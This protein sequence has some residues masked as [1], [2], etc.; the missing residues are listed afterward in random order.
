MC[1]ILRHIT[2]STDESRKSVSSPAGIRI[3]WLLTFEKRRW[4]RK[5]SQS[6]RLDFSHDHK[7]LNVLALNL[8]LFL[9]LTPS[10]AACGPAKGWMNGETLLRLARE[11]FTSCNRKSRSKVMNQE[12]DTRSEQKLLFRVILL[13]D[14]D[15]LGWQV[16][17]EI[18]NHTKKKREKRREKSFSHFRLSSWL[19]LNRYRWFNEKW[20]KKSCRRRWRAESWKDSISLVQRVL[21]LDSLWSRLTLLVRC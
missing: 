4:R 2:H 8:F 7:I 14:I 12:E 13:T 19:L 9:A 6:I 20:R 18:V 17:T 3:C 21:S 15:W 16:V 1:R 10:V 11:T 5:E